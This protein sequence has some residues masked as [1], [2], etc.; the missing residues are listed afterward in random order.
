MTDKPEMVIVVKSG[1]L[2]AD[3]VKRIEEFM[4]KEAGSALIEVRDPYAKRYVLMWDV[5]MTMRSRADTPAGWTTDIELARRFLHEGARA[6][7]RCVF[8]LNDEPCGKYDY[9]MAK[10]VGRL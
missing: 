10:A 6:E 3:A 2:S 8:V 7:G 1:R 5:D 9:K 4:E